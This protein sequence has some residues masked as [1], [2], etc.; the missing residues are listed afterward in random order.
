MARI[1][2]MLTLEEEIPAVYEIGVLEEGRALKVAIHQDLA[3]HLRVK[4]QV[5]PRDHKLSQ[6]LADPSLGMPQFTGFSDRDKPWGFGEVFIPEQ[7]AEDWIT[8]RCI[9]PTR[10]GFLADMPFEDLFA[11]SGSLGVLSNIVRFSELRSTSTAPQLFQMDLVTSA[12]SGAIEVE[13]A[14]PMVDWIVKESQTSDH[15]LALGPMKTAYQYMSGY[16][17]DPQSLRLSFPLRDRINLIVPGN[18]A[19]ISSEVVYSYPTMTTTERETR[20]ILKS[21]NV[22]RP[23]QQLTLVMGLATMHD[24]VRNS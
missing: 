6:L 13:L 9:L 20:H 22:D 19:S 23:H 3:D 18:A 17:A 16:E 11:L 12:T 5:V 14:R 10:A 7:G 24:Q 4:T 1:Q 8:W 15:R 21:N 2:K